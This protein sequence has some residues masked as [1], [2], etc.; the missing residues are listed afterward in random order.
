MIDEHDAPA[1]TWEGNMVCK[2][3][4]SHGFVV[5]SRQIGYELY[6]GRYELVQA[7]GVTHLFYHRYRTPRWGWK[8]PDR[9]DDPLAS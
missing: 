7:N 2:P 3:R 1:L 9:I 5:P 4:V 6:V 8:F